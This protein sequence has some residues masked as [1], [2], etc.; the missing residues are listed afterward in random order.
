MKLTNDV[1]QKKRSSQE[2]LRVRYFC[3]TLILKSVHLTL[4]QVLGFMG[5]GGGGFPT[6]FIFDLLVNG[7]NQSVF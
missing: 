5:G 2:V 7:A 1:M 3:S 4:L 6:I